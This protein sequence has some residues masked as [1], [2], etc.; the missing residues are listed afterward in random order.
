MVN[1][2]ASAS[3]CCKRCA[4]H[5]WVGWWGEMLIALWMAAGKQLIQWSV[6]VGC[7]FNLSRG[8]KVWPCIAASPAFL[9]LLLDSLLILYHIWHAY[10]QYVCYSTVLVH[11]H[12]Y[13]SSSTALPPCSTMHRADTAKQLCCTACT[14]R[15]HICQHAE[16]TFRQYL[17]IRCGFSGTSSS[18]SAELCMP[19]AR[20]MTRQPLQANLW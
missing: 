5:L 17:H 18:S 15:V 2:A 19:M 20:R 16:Y 7:I 13:I 9:V 8:T 3:C 6:S 10:T 11:V 1:T 4:R 12:A 14:H